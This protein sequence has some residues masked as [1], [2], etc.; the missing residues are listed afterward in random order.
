MYFGRE[1]SIGT[2]SVPTRHCSHHGHHL[3]GKRHLS[4][5]KTLR[6]RA[7]SLL[8]SR[9]SGTQNIR[10]EKNDLIEHYQMS[11]YALINSMFDVTMGIMKFY[12]HTNYQLVFHRAQCTD[13]FYS[14][15]TKS[16]QFLGTFYTNDT[17]VFQVSSHDTALR[18]L[19]N[20]SVCLYL[21]F[22]V[23][24]QMSQLVRLAD[25]QVHID[26]WLTVTSNNSLPRVLMPVQ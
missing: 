2:N 3:T 13:H 11:Q 10:N 12:L 17:Q 24:L 1:V 14:L 19:A 4:E 15:Y 5:T 26:Q 9:P 6:Q 23:F 20:R 16:L 25:K 18:V 21:C 8:M 22:K 7:H